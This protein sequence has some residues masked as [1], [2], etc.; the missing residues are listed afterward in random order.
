MLYHNEYCHIIDAPHLLD[1]SAIGGDD[2]CRL[3]H[4]LK[5]KYRNVVGSVVGLCPVYFRGVRIEDITFML[6]CKILGD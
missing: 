1:A 6:L 3:E 4:I 2:E 5:L